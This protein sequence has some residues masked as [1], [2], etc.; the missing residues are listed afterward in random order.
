MQAAAF[1]FFR[2]NLPGRVSPH[3]FE[4]AR[5]YTSGTMKRVRTNLRLK[6]AVI[7]KSAEMWLT[8]GEP[9]QALLELQRLTRH[10]WRHPWTEQVLW[11]AAH[12]LT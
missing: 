4:S 9:R 5:P 6:D 12:G 10:A 8:L 7:V 1:D 11:Q 2:G 3:Y